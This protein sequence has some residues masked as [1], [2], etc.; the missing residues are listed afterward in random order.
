VKLGKNSND[1]CAMLDKA[2]GGKAVKKSS[3]V[4]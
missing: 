4:G 2:Y 3:I 1:T